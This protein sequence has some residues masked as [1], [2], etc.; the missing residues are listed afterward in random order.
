MFTRPSPLSESNPQSFMYNEYDFYSEI[1]VAY[2]IQKAQGKI[3]A[4][5]IN[6]LWWSIVC[7]CHDLSWRGF[8]LCIEK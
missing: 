1:L 2:L 3:I 4:R 8:G 7:L 5:S 6:F